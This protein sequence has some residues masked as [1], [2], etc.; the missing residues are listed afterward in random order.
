VG[1]IEFVDRGAELRRYVRTFPSSGTSSSLSGSSFLLLKDDVLTL[2]PFCTDML[3]L[4][5]KGD[6]SSVDMLVGDIYGQ[7]Y[8]KIGLKSST[9]ASSFGKVF[10]KGED[11]APQDARE[12]E[13]ER[14]KSFKPE[15][16]SRSLLYA[17][18]NNIGQI[19]FVLPLFLFSQDD[20]AHPMPRSQLHERR[21][22]QPRPDLLRRWLHSRF[23]P[24]SHPFP[25]LP[26]SFLF[27]FAQ[28]TPPPSPPYP[29][30]SGSGRK[31][32]SEPS[33][34]ATKATS[35]VSGRG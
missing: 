29:T 5:D 16:I 23:V 22:A 24:F 9:I 4:A 27:Y 18:S 33:S 34:S 30:P 25:R 31:E 13:E 7:D 28:V 10:R 6:N 26:Y 1:V 35:A 32:R 14:K 17:I 3:A 2:F 20:D 12:E 15:D 11:G 8:Q 21:K 19:A